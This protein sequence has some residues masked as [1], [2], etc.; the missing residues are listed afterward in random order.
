M[1]TAT[2][3]LR[4]TARVLAALMA[5]LVLLFLIGEG[6]HPSRLK[7]SEWTLMVPFFVT[8]L[9]LCL[10]WRW[11]GL[12]GLLVVAGMGSFY[13]IHFAQTGFGRFP[14]GFAFPLLAAPG[15]LFLLYWLLHR[16]TPPQPG[17]H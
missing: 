11:E 2:L 8:W 7:P 16:R 17:Q 10:G 3:V 9:G 14:N 13:F 4:W 6:F 1:R 5:G 15:I 12:G